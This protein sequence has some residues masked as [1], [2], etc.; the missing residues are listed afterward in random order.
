MGQVKTV[1]YRLIEFSKQSYLEL[2]RIKEPAIQSILEGVNQVVYDIELY[3]TICDKAMYI[4]RG[5]ESSQAFPDGNKRVALAITEMFL[6]MN[7]SAIVNVSQKKKTK[8]VLGIATH[9]ITKEQSLE[10]CKM[11]LKN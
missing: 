5:I 6:N 11:G 8:F 9:K 4:L 10:C 3:P 7:K 1:H 2:P